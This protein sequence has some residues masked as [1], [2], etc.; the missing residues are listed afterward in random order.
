MPML[1]MVLVQMTE[2]AKILVYSP[3]ISISHMQMCARIADALANDG[4]D[5]TILNVEYLLSPS[6]NTFTK[7]AK[8]VDIELVD[9]DGIIPVNMEKIMRESFESSNALKHYDFIMAYEEKFAMFCKK[10]VQSKKAY[11]YIKNNQFDMVI[12]EHVDLCGTAMSYMGGIKTNVLLS[13]CPLFEHTAAIIGAPTP[14]SYVPSFSF[15]KL[16]DKLN[17]YERLE[18]VVGYA[19]SYL[20]L[21]QGSRM[22]NHIFQDAFREAYDKDVDEIAGDSVITL[23]YA[24][25]LIEFP[26]P[27]LPNMVYIGAMG[28]LEEA[29]KAEKN[30]KLEKILVDGGKAMKDMPDY[31][32]I[33]KHDKGHEQLSMFM[34]ADNIL[35][36]DWAPQLKILK[37]NKTKLFVSHGGYNSLIESAYYGVPTI[38]MGSFIDQ[39]RNGKLA[40]RNGWGMILDKVAVRN[41]NGEKLMKETMEFMLNSTETERFCEKATRTKNLMQNRPQVAMERLTSMIRMIEMGNG[42][43]PE[44]QP[45]GR[46]QSFFVYCHFDVAIFVLTTCFIAVF[47]TFTGLSKLFKVMLKEFG[48]FKAKQD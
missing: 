12:N 9:R 29:K 28:L 24:D 47:G 14:V 36:T 34:E 37:N 48:R 2:S 6:N 26:R 46:S 4:H 40:E 1:L 30:E 42:T 35:F 22:V 21:R 13:S 19:T 41:E 23:I 11:N 8:K 17:F 33:F 32:F 7:L 18:N 38:I 5:V 39:Y 27:M 31:Q 45:Y 20:G 25:E 43:L 44:L 15:M 16:G 3:T 10:H